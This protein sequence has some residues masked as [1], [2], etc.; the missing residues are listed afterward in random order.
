MRPKLSAVAVRQ[1]KPESKPYK[2]TDG[3]GLYL[4]VN[5]MGK[6]WRYDYRFQGKRKT[7]SYGVFPTIT[8]EAA[9]QAH[10]DAKRTLADGIDP[11]EQKKRADGRKSFAAVARLWFEHW[12]T[13][14]ADSTARVVWRG[15]E[16][17]ILPFIG[18][19][20]IDELTAAQVRDCVKRIEARGASEVAKRQ[21]QRCSQIARF[22]VAHDYA[23][24]NP[25]SDV[26]PSDILK[27]RKKQNY[28]RVDSKELPVLLQAIDTYQGQEHTRLALQLMALTF[29]RTSELIKAKWPEF[30]LQAHRWEIPAERMKM[31]TPHMVPLSKQAVEVIQRLQA[32]SMSDSYVFPS[33]NRRGGHM[34]N[35]TILYA[36]YRMGYR[37]RMTGHG[38]RGVASTLL[39]EKGF[40]HE[41][42]ELQLAHQERDEVSASY[43]HALYL[44]PRKKMMQWW[45]DYLDGLR[46]GNL[47]DFPVKKIG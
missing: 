6:Y 28:A 34:S 26:N 43:N 2:L 9:R 25:V 14:K 40:A 37:S 35:N 4:L 15:L 1:A 27:P 46:K 29:V 45:G 11:A 10:Q 21:L 23:E 38:F 16:V 47:L 3:S 13:D 36:L 31:R 8:L 30:D 18:N 41:H 24:R 20:L 5:S 7:L 22:G 44:E 42:I 19:V 12:K 32:I 33:D 39:H 17:N